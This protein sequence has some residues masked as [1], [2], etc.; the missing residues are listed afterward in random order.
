MEPILVLLVIPAMAFLMLRADAQRKSGFDQDIRDRNRL[1]LIVVA[2]FGIGVV[3][4]LGSR[5]VNAILSSELNAT[6]L[7]L[8]ISRL[9]LIILCAMFVWRTWQLSGYREMEGL[10]LAEVV[11]RDQIDAYAR[12]TAV[13]LIVLPLALPAIVIGSTILLIPVMVMSFF[14]VS[15]KVYQNQLLWTLTVAVK[16]DLNAAD[17]VAELL[18][19]MR[20]KE[21]FLRTVVVV[22]GILFFAP[23]G[24]PLL[25]S[26]M[27]HDAFLKQLDRLVLTLSDGIPL[28]QALEMQPQLASPDLVG[29]IEAAEQS[30]SLKTVLPQ[31]AWQQSQRIEE[32]SH[33]GGIASM[34]GYSW[35]VIIVT[36]TVH[37]FI[38]YWIVPKFKAIFNDFGVELPQATEFV[39]AY[40]DWF[41]NYWYLVFPLLFAPLFVPLLAVLMFTDQRE[42]LPRW[43]LSLLPRLEAPMLLQRLS[44]AAE[45][46]KPLQESL[47]SL[48]NATPDFQRAR[49]FERLETRLNSGEQ[50][51]AALLSEGFINVRES[52]SL[53]NA[54]SIGHLGFALEAIAGS[55]NE[56]QSVRARVFAEFVNPFVT[57]VLGIAVAIFCIGMFLPI[58]K[59]IAELS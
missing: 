52:Q 42:L 15:A 21:P 7:L 28:H 25:F 16:N 43:L 22:F 10:S 2:M 5:F 50:I 29:A 58:V 41:V 55:M 13:A 9:V 44:Y 11:R 20:P 49:R 17:E 27:R 24:I 3:F 26:M 56:R 4:L 40:S 35:M 39:I 6:I 54:E 19:S 14:G 57:F 45:Q 23:I 32:A 36:V 31:L 53:L 18:E 12:A 1:Y 33:S 34:L 8:S 48:A 38:M 46:N 30:G 37:G 47:H 51:G 59:L